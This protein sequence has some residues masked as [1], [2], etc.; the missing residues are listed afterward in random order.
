MSFAGFCLVT[1]FY[2]TPQYNRLKNKDKVENG[3]EQLAFDHM[4]VVL[5]I[6]LGRVTSSNKLVYKDTLNSMLCILA[7]FRIKLCGISS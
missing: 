7:K 4:L 5:V 1:V 6:K 2:Y 3:K